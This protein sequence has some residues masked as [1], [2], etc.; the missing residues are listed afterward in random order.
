MERDTTSA[1]ANR[2]L[3]RLPPKDRKR[4]LRGC[5][6]VD[7]VFKTRLAEPGETIEHIHFPMTGF[8][9]LLTTLPGGRRLEVALVGDEGMLG[10][11]LVLGVATSQV[12][13]VV[14]GEGTALRMSTAQFRRE[15]KAS[16]ALRE[17]LGQYLYIRFG[18]LART[19]ACN[20]YHLV[21]ERLARWLLMTSDRSHSATFRITH[22]FLATMLGVRRVGVTK[23]ASALQ[24]RKLIRYSRGNI[25]IRDRPGLE[26]A[27]CGCY[28]ADVDTYEDMLPAPGL[29]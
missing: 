25:A 18:Q 14:Q 7:L 3:A 9:S 21:E 4:F 20:R 24:R 17:V 28:K 12:H 23:A 26:R 1:P 16:P 8:V 15:L 27:A 11:P 19:A 22:E 6:P 5:A 29:A 10:T 13:G 2:L